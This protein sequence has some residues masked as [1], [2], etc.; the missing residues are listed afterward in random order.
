MALIDF[1]GLDHA[2]GHISQ[3]GAKHV[4]HTK[5]CGLQSGID[6]KNSHGVIV[7]GRSRQSNIVH[8]RHDGL[9]AI[10]EVN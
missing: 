3:L 5:T 1:V 6:A 7:F 10:A 2:A 4:N 8:A 9:R